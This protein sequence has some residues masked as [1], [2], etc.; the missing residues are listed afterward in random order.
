[1]PVP[2]F[3]Q[4][5]LYLRHKFPQTSGVRTFPDLSKTRQSRVSVSQTRQASAPPAQ[6]RWFRL[7]EKS[8]APPALARCAH[9]AC[10]AERILL[11]IQ[12]YP[13]QERCMQIGVDSSKAVDN[14]R[15]FVL[16]T[17]DITRAILQFMLHDENETHDLPSLEAA[18]SKSTQWKPDLILL[19]LG[20][21]QAHGTAI[22]ADIKGGIEGVKILLVAEN[23]DDPLVRDCLTCGADGLLLKPL[24]IAAVRKKVDASLGRRRGV[25]PIRA[26]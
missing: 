4:N 20:M 18:L 7:C 21:I 16:D 19:G 8:A 17:H 9:A 13:P 3:A 2:R 5:H 26:V 11:F 10:V 1:V 25:I 14:K 23:A 22:L 24:T 6:R 15:V 12:A